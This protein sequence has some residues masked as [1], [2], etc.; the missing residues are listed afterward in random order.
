VSD[1]ILFKI[2]SGQARFIRASTERRILAVP[3]NAHSDRALIS[4]ARTWRRIECLL[5]E[6]FTKTEL[7]RRLGSKAKHPALQIGQNGEIEARTAMKV[8]RLYNILMAG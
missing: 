4:N 5:R 1:S 8:E 2:R 7:A 6:G 3:A